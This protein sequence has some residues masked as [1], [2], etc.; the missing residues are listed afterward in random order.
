MR[1]RTLL[2]TAALSVIAGVAHADTQSFV[3]TFTDGTSVATVNVT[4]V[5]DPYD[6]S[7][8]DLTSGTGV[9]NGL[10]LTLVPAPGANSQTFYTNP[11]L[12]LFYDNVIYP[13]GPT[14]VDDAGLAF[15]DG[16]NTYN[17]FYD[18]TG[19]YSGTVGYELD[20]DVNAT[21]TSSYSDTIV[22][23]T[24]PPEPG[25]LALLGTS[26]AGICGLVRRRV[27]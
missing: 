27:A 5:T 16:T 18:V 2:A 6:S 12:N 10:T 11:A 15:T 19:Q 25:G 26:L 9:L 17:P 22:T 24:P 3:V 23:I 4:G 7:A 8:Y 13:S 1:V 14:L 21:Q 20:T